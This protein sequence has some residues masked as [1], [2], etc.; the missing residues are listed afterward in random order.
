MQRPRRA[1]YSQTN[2]RI[3]ES[4]QLIQS[5]NSSIASGQESKPRKNQKKLGRPVGRG[6]KVGLL[7]KNNQNG[8][9]RFIP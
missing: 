1:I 2:Q 9:T 5:A 7:N 4:L 8:R 3:A 6:R